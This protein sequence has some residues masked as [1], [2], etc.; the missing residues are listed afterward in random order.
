MISNFSIKI[1][2]AVE[3][4]R[5]IP[6]NWKIDLKMSEDVADGDCFVVNGQVL[7]SKGQ[8]SLCKINLPLNSNQA[9]TLFEWKLK[10]VHVGNRVEKGRVNGGR[11]NYHSSKLVE[12]EI[13]LGISSK[14]DSV[15]LS[16]RSDTVGGHGIYPS[17]ASHVKGHGYNLRYNVQRHSVKK[18]FE[19][20]DVLTFQFDCT[21]GTL[22]V[23]INDEY[24]ILLGF[25]KDVKS[26]QTDPFYPCVKFECPGDKIELLSAGPIHNFIH[27]FPIANSKSLTSNQASSVWFMIFAVCFAYYFNSKK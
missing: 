7:E 17:F 26:L 8:N 16:N 20:A 27:S 2:L 23:Q 15:F 24:R 6:K 14:Q 12:N 3:K 5:L 21:S 9:A 18:I 25:L 4:I 11:D 1:L 10:I 19:Q 13:Q 22:F